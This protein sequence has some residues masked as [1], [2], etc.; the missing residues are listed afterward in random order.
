MDTVGTR[1][2]EARKRKAWTQADLGAAVFV[3]QTCISYWERGD[4][5][6]TITDLL[7]VAAALGVQAADLIPEIT[8]SPVSAPVLDLSF[9]TADLREILS[10]LER[11]ALTPAT[12]VGW[13]CGVDR[14]C[15]T[16][17]GEHW[18]LF[19]RTH[20]GTDLPIGGLHF[21]TEPEAAH[22]GRANLRLRH[23]TG[24]S[25]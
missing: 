16:R 5:A 9:L 17:T 14:T 11:S 24:H 21:N 12:V 15:T 4:R 8:Q 3:T 20:G 1:I 2:A 6:I 10:K 25:E 13:S 18:H 23:V 7:H 22:W 19:L